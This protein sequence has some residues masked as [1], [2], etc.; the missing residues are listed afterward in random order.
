MTDEE[1]QAFSEAFAKFDK[2]GNGKIVTSVSI[3]FR[4]SFE[5]LL[6]SIPG[7]LCIGLG[8][9]YANIYKVDAKDVAASVKTRH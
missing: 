2:D 3:V 6:F 4:F 9:F 1:K 8:L 7:K 5:L